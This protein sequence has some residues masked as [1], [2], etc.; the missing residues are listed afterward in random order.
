MK[1]VLLSFCALVCLMCL[2]GGPLVSQEMLPLS[3][4]V[5]ENMK[6]LYLVAGIGA[7][8]NSIP[9]SKTEANLILSRIDRASLP[10]TI[11]LV[12]DAVFNEIVAGLEIAFDD[13]FSFGFGADVSIES[14]Y[15]ENKAYSQEQ[16]WI[17]GFE[18]R[19]PLVRLSLDFSLL[20]FFYVYCD[21]QYGRNRVNHL[22][23]LS[24]FPNI[25]VG[26]IIDPK[27]PNLTDSDADI[28]LD[29]LERGWYVAYSEIFSQRF[30]TN[31]FE[32]AYDFD[33]QWPKRALA[34]FGDAHW[35]ISL[36]RDK[37]RWGNG[38]SGNF[39]IGDHVDYH[40]YA[41]YVTF[42]NRFKYEWL[43]VFFETNPSPQEV[44]DRKFRILMA[45]RLEYRLLD[46]ITVAVSENVMYQNNVFDFRYI[47]PAFIYH[48]VNNRSMLNAIAHVEL[49]FAFAK[50]LNVYA[51]YVM[52]QA[53]APYEAA[54]QSDA[55]GFLAG[56]EYA[57]TIGPGILVTSLEHALTSPAL[58]RRDG[59]DFL[60]FRK[61][62]SHS[63]TERIGYVVH[64]DYI[65]YQ[66]GGDAQVLQWDAKY[67][68]PN[69]GNIA[70]RIFGMRHGEMGFFTPHNSA[71]N[72]TGLVDY[73]G[74]TPSGSEVEESLV[75]SVAG[76]FYLLGV[77][78]WMQ[79]RLS[80]RLDWIGRRTYLKATGEYTAVSSDLQLF[81]GFSVTL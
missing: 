80:A 54:V 37:I 63:A 7:P 18:D 17:Y 55:M 5:Y 48:N 22:D 51:Q 11:Q 46:W 41:R 4:S 33:F 29:I 79:A 35:N 74:T 75:M 73:A 71:G 59:V 61:Y 69:T 40:E 58:Y 10:E 70:L 62:F 6:I 65:G 53:R 28:A 2:F 9:W 56:V 66:Y 30:L 3:S 76:E 43:N 36:A 13:V 34:V 14:Y 25:G 42:S 21:A 20:D 23:T 49:D 44:P 24:P 32:Y 8:S 81:A 47:N 26:A 72:N 27:D 60:M 16:D 31:V 77:I 15:H 67:L 68:I 38:N 12:F 50:G 45:H 1:R 19:K 57:Q 64:L 78:P 39:I 52:D